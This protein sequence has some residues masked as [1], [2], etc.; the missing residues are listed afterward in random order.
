MGAML[1]KLLIFVHRWMGV[2]L[3]L[4]F[5]LWFLSGMVMMYW[6]YPEVTPADRLS[7]AQVLEASRIRLSP[8]K[9]FAL[10]ESKEAPSD[11]RL[12]MFDGRPAYKFDFT[13]EKFIVYA[14]NGEMQTDLPEEMSLRIAS[15]WSGQPPATARV[16]KIK[17]ADQWTV[18][19]QFDE[20]RPLLKYTWPD[21]EA[22]YVST[23]TGEVVQYTTRASRLAAY[24]GAIP[25]WVYFTPLRKHASKWAQFV[26]WVAGLGTVAALLGIIVG[27]WTYS[28][29]KS[30]QYKGEPSTLPFVGQKRWHSILGLIFGCVA[31]TWAF[32]GMLSMDPFPK[33]QHGEGGAQARMAEVLQGEPFQLRDFDA[34]MPQEALAQVDPVFRAKELT[35]TSFAGKPFY[36][37][38]AALNETRIIPVHGEPAAEFD[39][40]KIIQAMNDAVQ[41]HSLADARLMTEYDAYYQDR[42][43]QRPLPVIF[44]R[45]NDE[46][47]S[48]Y[49][50]DPKT[51]RIVQSYNSR[52]RWNRWFYHGLHSIDFPLL[53][54]RRPL[55][56]II[57]LTLLLGGSSLSVTALILAGGVLRR[58]LIPISRR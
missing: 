2:T 23:V 18:S 26:I 30:F 8:Q 16:E 50:V 7:R 34:K 5:L 14:D 33:L 43:K 54:K 22:V 37:A 47:N 35:F 24:F 57:V 49:Y 27:V 38:A 9:A 53:Y 6:T 3:C 28:P 19:G 12:E 56:D 44:V 10:L 58:K 36:L 40:S 17:E 48:T 51:A 20:L 32:S 52:S 21:G 13:G 55:W 31:C 46:E 4:L 41:P 45:V 42:H 15:A 29:S 39:A 11:L 1:K 25:H